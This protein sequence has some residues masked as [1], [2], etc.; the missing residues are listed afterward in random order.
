MSLVTNSFPASIE[1]APS[2]GQD[3][4]KLSG[5]PDEVLKQQVIIEPRP[6]RSTQQG[7]S[8]AHQWQIVWPVGERWKNPLMGWTST[9][10][11]MSNMRVCLLFIVF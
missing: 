11:P 2:R 5:M 1:A 7:S 4:Q 10:D 9:A 8:Y 3:I 6:R